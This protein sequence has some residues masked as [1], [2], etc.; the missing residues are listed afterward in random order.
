MPAT[1]NTRS[2]PRIARRIGAPVADVGASQSRARAPSS[3]VESRLAAARSR[4]PRRRARRAACATCEPM[5]PVAPVTSDQARAVQQSR[6]VR[7]GDGSACRVPRSWPSR[8]S[9]TPATTSAGAG[10]RA[11]HP[12]GQPV[13]PLEGRARSARAR[14]PTTTSTTSGCGPRRSC[15][16]PRSPRSAT[17]SRST[18]RCSTAG[19]E[20]VSIHLA[21]GM[22]GTVRAA[23]QAREQLGERGGARPRRRLGHRVRRRGSGRAGGRRG[24]ARRALDGAAVAERARRARAELKMWFAIDTL[25]YLRR[26]GRIAGA[27][28]WLGSALKIKPILTVESEITPIERVRTSRRAF[29][30][31]VELLR[32][33]QRRRRRRAGWSS[34]SR[35]P[36]EAA[37][38]AARGARDLRLRAARDLGDRP[39]DRHPR[40][41]GLLGAGALPSSLPVAPDS[42]RF[43]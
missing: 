23:E 41:P 17:S 18:S 33:R 24:G 19:D 32:S 29:E 16:P 14:S 7:S 35:H 13:R 40:R 37:E 9:P 27:Q 1:W 8:S 31:M 36:R 30:R 21:G 10:R 4:A 42:A 5:K 20:I 34:T 2:T 15:R 38:L 43:A 12:R 22:S 28:A 25:E 11:R 39:G 6:R 3:G 26:G